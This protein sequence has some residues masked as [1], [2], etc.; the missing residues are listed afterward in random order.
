MPNC[1]QLFRKSDPKT[2]VRFAVIDEEL[3][4][5]LNEPVN[6]VRYVVGWFDIIGFRI[7]GGKPLGSKELR[8]SIIQDLNIGKRK[9]P[10][11]EEFCA[12]VLK[13]LDYLEEHFTSYAWVQIGRRSDS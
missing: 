4:A 5:L 10:E 6:P 11:E 2:P 9:D 12:Q 3:C 8:G 13:A 1:F 7:A